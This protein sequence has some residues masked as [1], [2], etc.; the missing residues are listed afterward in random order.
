MIEMLLR[1]AAQTLA[2]LKTDELEKHV[3][4][5][6]RSVGHAEDFG[7]FFDPTAWIDSRDNGSMQ[8]AKNQLEIAK[9]LLAARK[10]IDKREAYAATKR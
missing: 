7:C 10:A 5:C 9:H 2:M 3:E 1:S 8:D 6:A 4:T